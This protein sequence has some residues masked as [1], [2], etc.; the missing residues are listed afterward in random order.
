MMSIPVRTELKI[1][2]AATLVN[3]SS[4]QMVDEI[5]AAVISHGT[6]HKII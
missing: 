4:S 5:A 6:C 2:E 1:Q 3:A